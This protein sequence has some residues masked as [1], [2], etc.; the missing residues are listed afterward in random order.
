MSPR[1]PS[2]QFHSPQTNAFCI[3][4]K[5]PDSSVKHPPRSPAHNPNNKTNRSLV[6]N[7][8]PAVIGTNFQ[9]LLLQNSAF[10]C[11]RK[12]ILRILKWM[13]D[14]WCFHSIFDKLTEKQIRIS[15]SSAW[16][17]ER[18]NGDR[19]FSK[20]SL[21]KD[22]IKKQHYHTTRSEKLNAGV[23]FSDW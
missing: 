22:T 19:P 2:T 7:V 16:K 12:S 4:N 17:A 23:L 11:S 14:E 21:Q 20:Q 8:I 18:W 1:S 10:L 13:R 15:W 6:Q 3:P 5:R 9:P